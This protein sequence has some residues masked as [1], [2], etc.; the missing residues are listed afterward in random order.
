MPAAHPSI[1]DVL[2][3]ASRGDAA[4]RADHVRTCEA[5]QKIL[6]S[7]FRIAP[8]SL[9]LA[10]KIR[11]GRHP[12][13][14]ALEL[15]LAEPAT[16]EAGAAARLRLH[17]FLHSALF[18]WLVTVLETGSEGLPRRLARL[19]DRTEA[20]LAGEATAPTGVALAD[21]SELRLTG[22]ADGIQ[23]DLRGLRLVC[24]G[25]EFQAGRSIRA[26]LIHRGKSYWGTGTFGE[27]DRGLCRAQIRLAREDAGAAVDASLVE[28]IWTTDQD[29]ETERY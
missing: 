4:A 12:A 25:P 11:A 23:Y 27:A 28:L 22:E 19:L 20:L 15:Y 26:A 3:T 17:R 8:P 16:D 9:L 2:D 13:R 1:P 6:L 10:A 24:Y 18:R 5:C 29:D 21:D 7:D 14:R